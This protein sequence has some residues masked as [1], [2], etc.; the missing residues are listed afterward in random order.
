MNSKFDCERG[1]RN[2]QLTSLG[3]VLRSLLCT[4]VPCTMEKHRLNP[5]QGFHLSRHQGRRILILRAPPTLPTFA[6]NRYRHLGTRGGSVFK[7][8][9][10]A[11]RLVGSFDLEGG[12]GLHHAGLGR[13][14]GMVIC[15]HRQSTCAGHGN[16]NPAFQDCRCFCAA[17]RLK[18]V[19]R[20]C[21]FH[22]CF[23]GGEQDGARVRF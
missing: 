17:V 14:P 23:G 12:G 16:S 20:S 1:V 7:A 11:L 13:R 5:E 3:A 2:S 21:P 4:N 22:F 10:L 15:L 19:C 9:S 18:H 8:H 6:P